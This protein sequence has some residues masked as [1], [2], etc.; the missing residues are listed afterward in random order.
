MLFIILL[1]MK[2]KQFLKIIID[3]NKLTFSSS[4][5]GNIAT[6]L[7]HQKFPAIKKSFKY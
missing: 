4:L 2:I 1:N 5:D 3:R 6:G 7:A